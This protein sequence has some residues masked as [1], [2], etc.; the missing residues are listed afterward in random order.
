M[1]DGVGIIGTTQAAAAAPVVAPAAQNSVAPA[2]TVDNASGSTATALIQ[3]PKLVLDPSAGFIT[4]YLS[5]NGSQVVSQTPSAITVAYLRIG[6]TAD[7]LSKQSAELPTAP[8]LA[9]TA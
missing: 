6:L 9:T 3:N 8:K 4:E 1:T 2:F 5:A 7:G